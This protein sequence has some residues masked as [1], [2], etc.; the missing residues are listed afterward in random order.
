MENNLQKKDYFSFSSFEDKLIAVPRNEAENESQNKNVQD[1]LKN[2]FASSKLNE[3]VL[4]N[5][6]CYVSYSDDYF[7]DAKN[8][9]KND[10]FDFYRE[11]A[12]TNIGM[13]FTGGFL[14][15]IISDDNYIKVWL[16]DKYIERFK[17]FVREIHSFGT[18]IFLQIKSSLGRADE[19]NKFFNLL[20]YSA[21]YNK[22]YLNTKFPCMR[23]S[24]GICNKI[25]D[26]MAEIANFAVICGFDGLLI[27][28]D[29]FGFVGEI[30]SPELNRRQFGYY[31]QIYDF[32]KNLFLKIS[33][34]KDNFP[35]FYSFSIESYIKDVYKNDYKNINS[36]KSF[37]MNFNKKILLDFLF[38]LVK[39]GVDGFIL[40]LGT[41]ETEF[42]S[43]SS[44]FEEDDIYENIYDEINGYFKENLIKNR[45]GNDIVFIKKGLNKSDE[46]NSENYYIDITNQILSDKKYLFKLKENSQFKNCI[47]CGYCS[48]K[49][50]KY[51]SISCIINPR[52]TNFNIVQTNEK[53][54]VI[55]SGI[56]GINCAIFLAK[57]GFNV[58]IYERLKDVNIYGKLRDIYGYNGVL[59]N[60][61]EFLE[62]EINEYEK[63]GKIKI[64]TNTNFNLKN[65]NFNNYSN[66]VIA[67]GACER[68]SKTPGAV[69]KNVKNIY[70][71]LANKELLKGKRDFVIEAKSELSLSL[72]QYLLLNKK[73]VT[74]LINSVDFLF[75]MQNSKL[76]Y[77]LYSLKKLNCKV[78]LQ[79]KI[80]KIEDDFVEA[81][82]NSKLESDNF[83][84]II[85]NMKSGKKYKYLAKAK[86]IDLDLFIYEPETYANNRLYYEL[87]NSNYNGKIF[88][89]GNALYPCDLAESIKT[90]FFVAKNI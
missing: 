75:K 84:S 60:Y 15:N 27:D 72:A 81:V 25:V 12:E 42:L 50:N 32:V 40:K 30:S 5:K 35:I 33:S 26:E 59:K 34:L 51:N 58:E 61:N 88:M 74:L 24:D 65:L 83:S 80:N 57:R 87:V 68:F 6:F 90:A 70:D 29:L 56:S 8:C 52:L 47:K 17:N 86:S 66:I 55:G 69:L 37:N 9:L 44:E 79:S 76:T 89:I 82:I 20:N 49:T 62:K 28:G 4:K 19:K 11:I 22:N 78:Y 77:Y 21:S 64:F 16:D 71:V 10:F 23:A 14:A 73:K 31:S 36:T 1:S 53:I 67:T 85:L 48:N 39:Y 7:F 45:F 13:I 3:L 46:N 63:L 38:K 2:M 41:Y 18:K 43:V 54:A